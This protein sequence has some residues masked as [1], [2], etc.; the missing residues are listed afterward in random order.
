MKQHRYRITVE[1]IASADG[2]PGTGGLP[3]EFEV[4]NHDE[5]LSLVERIRQRDL[6]DANTATA[7]TVGLKLFS[8]VMLENRKHPLFDEFRPH[9]AEFMKR[10]KSAP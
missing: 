1:H 9:F 2:E 6:F 8:E 5:I 4:G 10:L 3:L 7:F